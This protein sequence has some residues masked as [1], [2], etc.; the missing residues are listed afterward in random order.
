[1]FLSC[2]EVGACMTIQSVM[3]IN[4]LFSLRTFITNSRIKAKFRFGDGIRWPIVGEK[5][6]SLEDRNQFSVSPEALWISKLLDQRRRLYMNSL[7]HRFSRKVPRN[8]VPSCG[9][10]ASRVRKTSRPISRMFRPSI[11]IFPPRS[12]TVLKCRR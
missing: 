7:T 8:K 1:M 9:T 6:G 3:G 5:P 12:S 11:S 4:L 2:A 10:N